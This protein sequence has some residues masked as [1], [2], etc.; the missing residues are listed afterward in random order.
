MKSIIELLAF[1]K[2]KEAPKAEPK[3][4]LDHSLERFVVAQ[5]RMYPRAL[6]VVKNGRKMTHWI[7]YIFPQ[8]KGLGHSSN[9]Q[10]YGLFLPPLR[11][12]RNHL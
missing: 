2:M 4:R 7:W 1:F 3:P 12:S 8:L 5:E 10:Y 11:Q 9:S 6:E